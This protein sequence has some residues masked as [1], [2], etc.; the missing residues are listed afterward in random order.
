MHT[1]MRIFIDNHDTRRIFVFG[2]RLYLYVFIIYPLTAAGAESG[3]AATIVAPADIET[4]GSF[5]I[6]FPIISQMFF[7]SFLCLDAQCS[8]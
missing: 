3:M 1:G 8:A 5:I 6:I 2:C 4:A 7:F